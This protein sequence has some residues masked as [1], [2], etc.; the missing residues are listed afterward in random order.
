M[1]LVYPDDRELVM[2]MWNRLIAG[3][4]VTFEMRWKPRKGTSDVSQWVVSSCIPIVDDQDKVVSVA[5]NTIDINPQ[6]KAHD[7]TAA[8]LEALERWRASEEKFVRFAELT[9]VAIYIF[10]PEKG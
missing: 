5:G 3:T 9:P 4:P 1:D 2:A 10:T 6:K 7:A 8:R